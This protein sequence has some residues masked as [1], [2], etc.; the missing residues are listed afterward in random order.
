MLNAHY[1]AVDPVAVLSI[2]AEVGVN[3]DLYFLVFGES[4]LNDGVAVVLYHMFEAF[5][6]MEHV[7]GKDIGLGIASFAVVAGGGTLIGILV[8]YICAFFTR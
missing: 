5:C 4:I 3:P 8:G 2:F 7:R 6:D 1:S